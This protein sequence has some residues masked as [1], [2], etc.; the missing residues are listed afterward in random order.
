MKRFDFKVG[1]YYP[2]IMGIGYVQAYIHEP[3]SEMKRDKFPS[4]VV[5]PGG[6]Y[7]TTSEREAEPVAM[8]FYADGYNVFVLRYTTTHEAISH[9]AT[10][11]TPYPTCYKEVGAV[12]DLIKKK[13]K[14]WYLDGKVIVVGFSAG[15]HLAATLSTRY[16]D[17][18]VTD[19][20]RRCKPDATILVYPVITG[21]E[22]AHRPSFEQLTG[23]SDV[24]VHQVES[25]ENYVH[26]GMSPVY[27]CHAMDDDGV[28]VRNSLLFV[29]KL[30]EFKVDCECHIYPHGR[31]G[32]STA[33]SLVNTPF[34]NTANWVDEALS[35][36]KARGLSIEK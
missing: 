28:D 25:V 8:R 32:F 7:W 4:V 13:P 30:A 33:T 1:E 27:V 11:I 14:G 24:A 6:S 3:N 10:G 19:G 23:T 15:G 36:L 21:D 17:K 29:S 9:E 12:V 22:F 2:D 35:F 20:V 34:D 5:V 31:H 16:D 18:V 26:E